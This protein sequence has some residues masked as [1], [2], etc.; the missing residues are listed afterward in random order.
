MLHSVCYSPENNSIH[1]IPLQ[2]YQTSGRLSM[3][4]KLFERQFNKLIIMKLSLGGGLVC[5]DFHQSVKYLS[6]S[7]YSLVGLGFAHNIFLW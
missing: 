4:I 6:I 3:M 5:M 2:D 7:L 1:K